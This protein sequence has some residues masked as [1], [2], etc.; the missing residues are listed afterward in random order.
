MFEEKNLLYKQGHNSFFSVFQKSLK[1]IS[2]KKAAKIPFF[3][4]L[5]TKKRNFQKQGGANVVFFHFGEQ[6]KRNFQKQGGLTP[7]PRY[8]REFITKNISEKD[9]FLNNKVSHDFCNSI[10][11]DYWGGVAAPTPPHRDTPV[12]LS[13]FSRLVSN[14]KL[15]LERSKISLQV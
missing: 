1:K 3:S 10:L 11:F 12:Y 9:F 8:G 2:K 4:T 14:R 15:R 6:K 13:L 5:K 7:H